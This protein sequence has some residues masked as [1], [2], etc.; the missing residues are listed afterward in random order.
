MFHEN[1]EMQ[2]KP[3]MNETPDPGLPEME[4]EA[5]PES[6]EV[7]VQNEKPSDYELRL[8]L[9]DLD[10]MLFTARNILPGIRSR[11][12][13]VGAVEMSVCDVRTAVQ[14]TRHNGEVYHYL[15]RLAAAALYVAACVRNN[16]NF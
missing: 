12:E 5:M 15:R 7:K 6:P 4:P 3:Q 14:Q 2:D 1:P 8:E 13:L 11:E 9:Q 16:E 10:S